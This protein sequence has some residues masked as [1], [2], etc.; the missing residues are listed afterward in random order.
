MS[1]FVTKDEFNEFKGNKCEEHRSKLSERIQD[2]RLELEKIKGSLDVG[3]NKFDNI[4]NGLKSVEHDVGSVQ[5]RLSAFQNT[6]LF[7]FASSLVG[8]IVWLIQFL[9]AKAVR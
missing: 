7:F 8:L 4:I 6:L 2:I 3:A 1:D 5:R 9:L